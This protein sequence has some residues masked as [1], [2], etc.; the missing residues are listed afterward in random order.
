M[1]LRSLTSV[2]L[3]ILAAILAIILYL[4]SAEFNFAFDDVLQI[5][6]N[7]TVTANN[8]ASGLL[9][10]FFS[11]TPP[12]N[13]FRPLSIFT[14]KLNHSVSQL[15]PY[16]YHKTNIALFAIY[17]IVVVLFIRQWLKSS[18]LTLWASLI[19]LAHPLHT[20]VVA[21][22][23]GRAELLAALFGLLT[24]L[25]CSQAL[26]YSSSEIYP[27]RTFFFV[28]VSAI[29]LCLACL[30][31]ESGILFAILAPSYAWATRDSLQIPKFS[32]ISGPFVALS[33]IAYGLALA[34]PL[35][36][37][38]LALGDN[39]I[40]HPDNKVWVENPLFHLPAAIRFIPALEIL[41]E[42]VVRI[43]AP[44]HLSADYSQTPQQLFATTY[45]IHGLIVIASLG[46]LIAF[47][48]LKREKPFAF[49]LIWFFVAFA[50]TCN[51][52]TPIGTIMGERLAFT[53]SLGLTVFLIGAI[54][55][56]FSNSAQRKVLCAFAALLFILF[57]FRTMQRTK[58]WFNN[59]T[60]FEATVINRP[61]SP[62]AHYLLAVDYY[63]NSKDSVKAE[64]HLRE[65][66]KIHP[67]YLVAQRLMADIMLARQDW[68]RLEYWYR[69]ILDG[70]PSQEDVR[71]G[72][73]K[74]LAAKEAA[75]S[76]TNT[77]Q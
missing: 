26:K 60:L 40:I 72:L 19:Y 38:Y 51:I 2:A 1:R 73:N 65:A 56:T 44:F 43:I 24:C 53:P 62:K 77:A 42:Y 64:A 32:A 74:L 69:R 8:T 4:P 47:W 46:L 33:V 23:I 54:H 7:P 11:P 20:E 70:D 39:F 52:L 17:A 59:R 30:S 21:N 67:D 36:L 55:D 13:L 29:T 68:P 22:V 34:L 31:K 28:V 9:A 27:L 57:A 15:G 25:S 10:P 48:A 35:F 50:L 3:P 58:L 45:S 14:Y 66:L 41:G 12:G 5:I 16:D 76:S 63:E 6:Y 37:R 71:Q 49:G 75:K 61:D 18:S